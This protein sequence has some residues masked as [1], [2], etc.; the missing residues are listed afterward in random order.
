MIFFWISDFFCFF[1]F[2]SLF[3]VYHCSSVFTSSFTALSLF[4][5]TYRWSTVHRTWGTVLW[6]VRVITKSL[7]VDV[8]CDSALLKQMATIVSSEHLAS[9]WGSRWVPG[10]LVTMVNHHRAPGS[11]SQLKLLLKE[12]LKRNDENVNR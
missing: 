5:F 8:Y 6:H 7:L 1:E 12:S 3:V 10:A 11:I 9:W 2:F 4:T